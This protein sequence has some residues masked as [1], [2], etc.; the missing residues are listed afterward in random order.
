MLTCA[1]F[2]ILQHVSSITLT[3]EAARGVHAVAVV[4]S[5]RIH[6]SLTLIYIY[7]KSTTQHMYIHCM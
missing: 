1:V 4:L 5:A 6:G 2:I 3:G 7:S